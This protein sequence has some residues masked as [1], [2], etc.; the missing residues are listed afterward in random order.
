MTIYPFR[1][2]NDELF[3]QFLIRDKQKKINYIVFN[4][5]AF[6]QFDYIIF[7]RP[8]IHWYFMEFEILITYEAYFNL[9]S[10]NNA[11]LP[12]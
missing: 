5:A 7:L 12:M 6:L 1:N 2:A 8:N 4:N 9:Q 3:L 10:P 11:C